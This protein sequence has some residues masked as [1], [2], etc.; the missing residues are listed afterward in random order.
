MKHRRFYHS[1]ALNILKPNWNKQPKSVHKL[2]EVVNM[3]LGNY[4]VQLL[5]R[6]NIE[7][8]TKHKFNKEYQ[9][10]VFHLEVV[11]RDKFTYVFDAIR[12]KNNNNKS[13]LQHDELEN[14]AVKLCEKVNYLSDELD[15][16]EIDSTTGVALLRSKIEKR[17]ASNPT[18]HF[19][20]L[21]LDCDKSIS[22]KRYSHNSKT[23]L[24][25][26]QSFNLAREVTAKLVDHLVETIA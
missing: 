4:M 22:V 23:K 19:F 15:V 25:T 3:E 16:I 26:S 21:R 2:S 18:I 20:E 14:R 1:M 5:D 7:G 11:D 9:D 10:K 8:K 24:K 6:E 13:K 17:G 12:I